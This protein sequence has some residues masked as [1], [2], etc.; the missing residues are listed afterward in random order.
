MTTVRDTEEFYPAADARG[1]ESCDAL[2]A[3]ALRG[4]EGLP[5]GVQVAGS[6]SRVGVHRPAC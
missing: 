4:T 5:A 6:R 3:A 1:A 2:A